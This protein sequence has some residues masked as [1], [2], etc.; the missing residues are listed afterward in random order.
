MPPA[1]LFFEAESC[2]VVKADMGLLS[3]SD[4][5]ALALQV[6]R[7]IDMHHCE[8]GLKLPFSISAS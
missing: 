4:P 1:L 3:P 2:Y 8:A 6:A 7:T 5:S